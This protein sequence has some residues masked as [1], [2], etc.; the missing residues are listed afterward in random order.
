MN[1]ER[2]GARAIAGILAE[3]TVAAR[4]RLAFLRRASSG[5]GDAPGVLLCLSASFNPLTVAHAA[6]IREARRIATPGEVLLLLAA[7]NVDKAVEGLPHETRLA[8]LLR[9]AASRPDLSIAAVAHGRFVD[10]LDAI[11][12][13][14]PART[15]VLFLLGFDTLVRLFDPKYYTDRSAALLRLF[16]GSEFI[17][18][19]R[20]PAPPGEI[21][22]FLSRPEVSPFASRIH[23]IRLPED[24]AGV[25]ATAVRTRLAR[26]ERIDGMVPWEIRRP[27]EALQERFAGQWAARG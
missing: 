15:R 24:I 5:P 7:A 25:S 22:A 3:L 17:A 20:A 13:A 6:L 12:A 8:L 18:A 9:Y 21:E 4:P 2:D 27:L 14:Y 23:S 1:A 10:K 16:A 11:R 19:N 26:G